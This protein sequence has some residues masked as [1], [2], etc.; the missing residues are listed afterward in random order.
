M[1]KFSTVIR[2]RDLPS[3]YH[4]L[5]RNQ[6]AM[7]TF[8]RQ[9]R[10]LTEVFEGIEEGKERQAV[11]LAVALAHDEYVDGGPL[12]DSSSAVKEP[13]FADEAVETTE[14]GSLDLS[15]IR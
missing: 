14:R 11:A 2:E 1:S 12:T 3:D 9:V 15:D 6:S 13:Q 10:E 8:K 5:P 4:D 7:G